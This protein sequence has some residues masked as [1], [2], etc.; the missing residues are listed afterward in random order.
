[1][2]INKKKIIFLTYE[3]MK[4][5]NRLNS[6]VELDTKKLFKNEAAD[7]SKVAIGLLLA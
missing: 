2:C 6:F 3:A 7:F 1:M 5:F 4:F